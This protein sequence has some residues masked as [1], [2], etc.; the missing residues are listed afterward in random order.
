MQLTSQQR[1][2]V[3]LSIL[4]YGAQLVSV[5]LLRSYLRGEGFSGLTDCQVETEVRYLEDKAL[6]KKDDSKLVSPEN[7]LYRTTANGRDYLAMQGQE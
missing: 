4:R 1:E 7:A 2:Q 3:R 6:F 5:S